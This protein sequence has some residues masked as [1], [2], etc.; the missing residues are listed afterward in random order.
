MRASHCT[1]GSRRRRRAF[2]TTTTPRHL[3][4][5]RRSSV[6]PSVRPSRPLGAA[7]GAGLGTFMRVNEGFFRLTHLK[8]RVEAYVSSQVP[9]FSIPPSVARD[10]AAHGV[11]LNELTPEMLRRQV[12]DT[13]I[14]P[15]T[16][17]VTPCRVVCR[18]ACGTC[19]V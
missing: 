8:M 19:H 3:P 18:V 14:G 4:H 5:D 12:A 15:V 9:L 6:R 17:H 16:A 7:S 1:Y 10:L 11:A 13:V 2:A